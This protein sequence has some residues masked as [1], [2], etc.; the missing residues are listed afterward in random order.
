MS[1][2]NSDKADPEQLRPCISGLISALATALV[3]VVAAGSA[4]VIALVEAVTAGSAGSA[5]V[6][7]VAATGASPFPTMVPFFFPFQPLV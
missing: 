5:S 7:A 3:K 1:D 6:I 4:G 2:V